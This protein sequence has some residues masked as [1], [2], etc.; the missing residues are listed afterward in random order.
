MQSSPTSSASPAAKGKNATLATTTEL[1]WESAWEAAIWAFLAQLF[2]SIV[3]GIVGGLWHDMLPS[4]PPGFSS[5]LKL[6]TEPG[7]SGDFGWIHQHRFVLLFSVFFAVELWTRWRSNPNQE[8]GQ[9]EAGGA[10]GLGRRIAHEWF[11]VIISNAFSA[12]V[13]VMVLQFVQQFSWT[14]ILWSAIS[15]VVRP[16]SEPIQ[17]SLGQ[18]GFLRWLGQMW[19][20]Y[21]QNQSKFLFWFLYSAGICD[22]LGLPNLKT[23]ARMLWSR[24]SPPRKAQATVSS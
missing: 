7:W 1:V 20:W 11:G 24:F 12:F 18:A 3:V 5:G 23:L 13:A 16:L 17:K 8:P 14:H 21:N 19:G 2:G 22:D 15:E 6:E 9:S 4:P 10:G